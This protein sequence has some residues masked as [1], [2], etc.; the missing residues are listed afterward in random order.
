LEVERDRVKG[1]RVWQGWILREIGIRD[2]GLTGVEFER[3]RVKGLG[4]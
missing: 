1:I 4:F 3:D 2:Q